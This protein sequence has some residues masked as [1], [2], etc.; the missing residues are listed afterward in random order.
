MSK[1]PLCVLWL[2]IPDSHSFRT[3]VLGRKPD[4][5]IFPPLVLLLGHHPEHFE[6]HLSLVSWHLAQREAQDKQL[7]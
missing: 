6:C 2:R 3:L 5:L 1:Q 7:L 4:L